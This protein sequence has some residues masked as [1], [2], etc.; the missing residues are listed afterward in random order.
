MEKEKPKVVK[1][2][3]KAQKFVKVVMSEKDHNLLSDLKDS[4]RKLFN[5]RLQ[6]L[7]KELVEKIRRGTRI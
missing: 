5:S 2:E 7:A 4:T 3:R 6:V 1:K